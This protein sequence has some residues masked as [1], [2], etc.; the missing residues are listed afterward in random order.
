MSLL[1][2]QPLSAFAKWNTFNGAKISQLCHS[3]NY[4][5]SKLTERF[6]IWMNPNDDFQISIT[7]IQ[8]QLLPCVDAKHLP[9]A[10]HSLAGSSAVALALSPQPNI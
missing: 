1:Y 2:R 4:E 6:F 3:S 10:I 9:Y 7:N 5:Y 8:Q